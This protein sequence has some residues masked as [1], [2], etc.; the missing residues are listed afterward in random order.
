MSR[1]VPQDEG[2]RTQYARRQ[3]VVAI[4]LLC[5]TVAG[6]SGCATL[7]RQP[8]PSLDEVVQMSA[9][10]IA[11]DQIILRL[12]ETGAVYPLSAS[13]ILDLNGKGVSP[14]VLDYMQQVFIEN[15]RRRERLMYGDPYWGGLYWGNPYWGNPYWGNPYWGYPCFECPYPYRGTVPFYMYLR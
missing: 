12:R 11:D 15:E 6:M 5:A 8:P 13:Q 3:Q 4:T 9:E 10:G 1:S 14:T 7:N 2:D